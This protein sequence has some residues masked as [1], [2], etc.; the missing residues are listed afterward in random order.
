VN[1]Y[2]HVLHGSIEASD[3]TRQYFQDYINLLLD[4]AT[5]SIQD[6]L[7]E[8]KRMKDVFE[9]DEFPLNILAK[10]Y[11][12]QILGIYKLTLFILDSCNYKR[13]WRT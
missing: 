7:S 8:A 10:L 4:D 13:N 9:K 3:E 11:L 2:R 5:F 12:E 1:A 6:I